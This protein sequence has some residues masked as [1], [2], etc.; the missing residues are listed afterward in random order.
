MDEDPLESL[1]ERFKLS[2][3]TLRQ[4]RHWTVSLRPAQP[5]VGAMVLSLQRPCTQLG[6]ILAREG[7]ELAEVFAD[8]EGALGATLAP[9]KI[10][11]LALMMVDV[12]V[13][14]HVLPRYR[15]DRRVGSRFFS[16]P[17]WPDPPDVAATL[18]LEQEDLDELLSTLRSALD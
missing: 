1:R 10:N 3:L 13:H 18:P 6:G 15:D 5:T 14:F 7:E 9:A 4:Y 2:D 11:Y 8:V 17:S 12:Q 16:D